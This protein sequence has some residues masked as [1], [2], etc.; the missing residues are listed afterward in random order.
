MR[1]WQ[2]GSLAPLRSGKYGKMF[3]H[4]QTVRSFKLQALCRKRARVASRCSMTRGY[5]SADVRFHHIC[6]N[7]SAL[8]GPER[9]GSSEGKIF[10]TVFLCFPMFQWP[11]CSAFMLGERCCHLR[12]PGRGAWGQQAQQTSFY[13]HGLEL[14]IRCG[15]MVV[16]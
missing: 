5:H 16:S 11:K 8:R 10:A 12:T 1:H 9:L 2:D 3:K 15:G 13:E 14:A 6:L 7:R 4:V